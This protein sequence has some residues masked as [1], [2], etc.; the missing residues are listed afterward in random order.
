MKPESAPDG[1]GLLHA[2]PMKH[3]L[4][5]HGLRLAQSFLLTI[6]ISESQIC[7]NPFFNERYNM[8]Q[9]KIHQGCLFC[10]FSISQTLYI[11]VSCFRV[12]YPAAVTYPRSC[13]SGKLYVTIP[14]LLCTLS[15]YYIVRR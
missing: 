2:R 14:S 8:F 11:V 12:I 9:R 13:S 1:Q 3:V 7:S 4:S 6:F 5:S 10:S 15:Y